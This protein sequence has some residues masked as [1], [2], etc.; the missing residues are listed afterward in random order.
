[1]RAGSWGYRRRVM[2]VGVDTGGT[3]TDVVTDDGDVVKVPSQ[4]ADPAGA[5]AAGIGSLPVS[6]LAHG[7]TVATNALLERRGADVALVTNAGF[8]DVIEIARQDRPSL[9]DQWAD[10]P[11]PLV[12]RRRRYGVPGRLA[13]DGSELEPVAPGRPAGRS[14]PKRSP[15]AC[16]TPTSTPATRSR[17]RRQL[18]A[19]GH[20]VTCSHEVSPEF[21]EYERTVTTVVNAYL[22]PAVPRLPAAAGRPGAGG[23]GDDVGGRARRPGL[24]RRPAGRPAAVRTGRRGAGGRGGRRGQRLPRCRQL[25]HGRH[26]HRRLP[27]RGRRARAVA[28]AGGRR[29]P[30]A[31]AGARRSTPIGAGGG[32]IAGIDPAA[33]CG[34]AASAGAVPGPACYG[35]GGT[36]ADGDR[37]RPRARPHPG[38]RVARR[39]SASLDVDAARAALDAR[40]GAGRGRGRGGRRRH[41]RRPCAW[42]R[43]QRG[44]DPAA[45][46]LVAFGG[47]GPLHACALADALGMAAV[48]VPARGR[49]ALGR[50]AAGRAAASATSCGRGRRRST[51]T[52]STPP[53]ADA[54]RRGRR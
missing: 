41:G 16:C 36:R 20:D 4:P 44:V 25:R 31:P 38:G 3:F 33:R 19:L 45:L 46:A 40:R 39:A 37:R 35:R 53:C 28:V 14:R 50:R 9:Y 52:G 27:D 13:A 21:R 24:R 26:V 18:R 7:T 32:S 2:R 54:R 1:M 48:I 22:R 15:S 12:A 49:R 17:W 30:G 29:V 6:L 10:R 42:C 23:A 47:A 5:V 34:R 51:T 11:A 8:E 43:S